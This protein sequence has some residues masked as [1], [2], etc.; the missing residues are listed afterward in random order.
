M[1]T[2][3][4]SGRDATL[5]LTRDADILT[6][7]FTMGH[8]EIATLNDSTASFNADGMVNIASHA[9]RPGL[10]L[11]CRVVTL[12]RGSRLSLAD[13]THT[14]NS[15][16]MSL[17]PQWHILPYQGAAIKDQEPT[18][19]EPDKSVYSRDEY[20][21][22]GD[23]ITVRHIGT[24]GNSEVYRIEVRPVE[25]NPRQGT[26]R[27]TKN[28]S[29]RLEVK[30][31]N[32][33]N[34]TAVRQRL[35]IVSRTQFREGMQEY[36]SWKRREGYDVDEL[37]VDTNSRYIVHNMIA[38]Y[39]SADSRRWPD[40][41]LIVGDV[42]QIQSYIG[43]S[44]PSGLDP[45]ATDLYYAEHTGDYLP[46]ALPGRWPVNDT[47]ELRAVVEKTL[48][49][50]Q[51]LIPDTT[52]FNRAMLVAGAENTS[53]APITTNGQVNYIGGRLTAT[54]PTVD[55]ICFRNPSSDSHRQEI[56]DGIAAGA[57]F[58]NY[59]AHCTA[60]GWSHPSV[61]YS[62]IDTLEGP[63]M[64]YINNCCLSNAFGGTCFGELLLRKSR[65]GAVGVIG[66]TNSTLWNEDYYW[67]VGPK[68]PF[69]LTPAYDSLMPGAFDSWLDGNIST[70]GQLLAAGN[71]SVTASGS[72]YDRFYWETY[73]LLGDP[74]L[75]PYLGTPQHTW[76]SI[77]PDSVEV[78]STH[79]RI[80][81]GNGV[82]V[83]AM[84]GGHLLGSVLM[85]DH[86]SIALNFDLPSDTL[87]IIFTA[88]APQLAPIIDTAWPVMPS[89]K[90]VTLRNLS[91]GD[92]TVDFTLANLGSDTLSDLYASLLCDD[93]TQ[94]IFS[95]PAYHIDTLP[96]YG[97]I[98]VHL[99]M[100]VL[101]WERG[102]S[103]EL[104]IQ[105]GSG[106]VT[107]HPLHIDGWLGGLY[108]TLTVALLNSDSSAATSLEPNTSYLLHPT[109][110]GLYDSLSL[111]VTMLPTMSSTH[112]STADE[113]L[114]ITTPDTITHLRLEA[115][116]IRGNHNTDYDWYIVA[117]RRM[118]SFEEGTTSHPWDCST[119]YPWHVDNSVSHTGTSSM[120]SAP[121]DY[122]QTSDLAI[123]VL[124]AE[125]DSISFWAKTSSEQN[126]DLLIFYI[127]G[128]R[129]MQHSGETSWRQYSFPLDVG[130]HQL[131]WRYLKDESN[132]AGSDCA[133]VDDIQLPLALWDAPYGW[134]DT[135]DNPTSILTPDGEH[136][137]PTII[138]NPTHG[139]LTVYGTEDGIL[140]IID[141]YGRSIH[142]QSFSAGG[143]TSLSHL[144]P[145]LYIV[146]IETQATTIYTRLIKL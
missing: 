51:C 108:P 99:T 140:T 9:G 33:S 1:C 105:S 118:D 17:R 25:Y 3:A 109:V 70:L 137:N 101:K 29:T 26:L 14:G 64:V 37:Y 61:S 106:D 102:W 111:S 83:T 98:S 90:A 74:T 119:L 5:A 141:T 10:P 16:T 31:N 32:A 134:F 27:I 113:N 91:I 20:M 7:Q 115:R 21:R 117:G 126:Y 77:M 79:V 146:K 41:L 56:L 71:M 68:Y 50:E 11:I 104:T 144:T 59:T 66:A 127:D 128:V 142:R 43:N 55:T 39:F 89:G 15:V 54:H 92:T 42:T 28:L 135:L 78:G 86:R 6:L 65:G 139:E 19:V 60:A 114:T 110:D 87:P 23:A 36:V 138:P 84:Q 95:V 130:S 69:S 133:W 40:Y 62:S 136:P 35:L 80:S 81:T 107:S 30:D 8:Y 88:T 44:R 94:A 116:L 67:A 100:M 96:P 38:P 103:G 112:H 123:N 72:P 125:P 132:N 45:H 18:S 57:G 52:P 124:L 131:K 122:R 75:R 47:A 34:P 22:D 48:R 13:E 24:M 121:I 53:P 76:L 143:K 97:E 4:Q 93:S 85:D 73:C 12:P 145:G 120:R 49:Y 2:L 46:D 129:Q 58:L 82:T 63:P